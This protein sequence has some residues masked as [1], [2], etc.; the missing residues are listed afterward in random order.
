LI[1]ISFCGQTLFNNHRSIDPKELVSIESR[2]RSTFVVIREE[3]LIRRDKAKDGK[4]RSSEGEEEGRSTETDNF[5]FDQE[6]T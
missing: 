2:K 4:P 1:W 6:R 3:E 5:T